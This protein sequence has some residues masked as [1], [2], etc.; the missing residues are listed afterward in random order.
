LP[1]PLEPTDLWPTLGEICAQIGQPV[2]TARR[3][4]L[5]LM[6]ALGMLAFDGERYRRAD[7]HPD[8]GIGL[9]VGG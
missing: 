5:P 2:R 3:E 8:G 9:T 4:V 7:R 6:V 1:H